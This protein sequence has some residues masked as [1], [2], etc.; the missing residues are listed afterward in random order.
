[1][2]KTFIKYTF[3]IV[4]VASSLILIINFL[5]SLRTLEA[6]QFST[7]YT[8]TEQM[9]H[10]LKNNRTE[11]QILNESLD[12]DYLTRAKAAAYVLDRQKDLSMDV[13]QMQYLADLLNV[14]ELHMIDETGI[15][16]AGSVSKYVGFDMSAH[17]QTRPFLTL[18]DKDEEDAYLIQETRPNAAE[19]KMM[20]YIG[21]YSKDLKCVVQVGFTPTRQLAAQSRNT[22]EYIFS[23]F[24]T[25]IGEE[26]FVVDAATGDLLGHSDGLNRDF[27][28]E[29]YQLQSLLTCTE[30]GYQQ[31]IT[32]PMY[33]VSRPFDDVLL[34]AALPKSALL[35]KLWGNAVVT[36]I[37]LLF[38]ESAVMILL[39]YLVR[40]K[41][42][43][44]IHHIIENLGSITNGNLDTQ[45]SVGGNQEFEA[46][47]QGI[48]KMVKS[49]VSLSDRISSIIKISGIPL[50]A[51]EY[52]KGVNHVFVS[53]GLREL[54]E[55]SEQEASRICKNAS[56]FDQYIRRITET[57]V[58]GEEDIYQIND[59]KYVRIHMSQ[60]SEGYLG[61][62][63]DVTE[64][65]L[66][67]QQMQYENSHDPLTGLYKFEHFKQSAGV[68][69]RKMS[70]GDFCAAVMLDLDYFK[71]INDTYGHDNGDLY[72]Q[73]F[74]SVMRS[75]PEEHF[76]T[77]RRSGDEFCMLI[78]NCKSRDEL[79]KYLDDFYEKLG[80][81]EISLSGTEKR[82]I[83]ASC[84]FAWTDHAENSITELLAHA[85]DALY[86]V[87]KDI[88][89]HYAEYAPRPADLSEK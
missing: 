29:C 1:M 59:S 27:S 62:I 46:L 20:K 23:R 13:S 26:L 65:I 32:E 10:T 40:R 76:L 84:G 75:M 6:R 34:C 37:Y 17:D 66:L 48:N 15:I 19:E 54:L 50:A 69:L 21:V 11:L 85:D 73:C 16:I 52:E 14:D 80:Q 87:K 70:D 12:E 7:F 3:F 22:Y 8:K 38:I 53:S 47:S 60:S 57:P 72:L 88:K 79:I 64:D 67:K 4:T 55:I 89:G 9:I 35:Q 83:S 86:E 58:K 43:N 45:V 2:Q 42:I 77:A 30:G 5:F 39:N 49:I 25:D 78:H 74:S 28:A 51:F 36:L 41:V 24:P 63:T 31:G 44:G 81:S 61:I 71:S 56:L 68:I 18:L 82:S 33:V